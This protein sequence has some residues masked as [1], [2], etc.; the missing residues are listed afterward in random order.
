MPAI[1]LAAG[2]ATHGG[3]YDASA[4]RAQR[5]TLALRDVAYIIR[6]QLRLNLGVSDDI[7]KFR[8]K[9]GAASGKDAASRCHT[10][11]AANSRRSLP[12]QTARSS[13][14]TGP[15][16]GRMLLD[17]EY[18]SDGG[19]SGIPIFFNARLEN[20]VLKVPPRFGTGG[21]ACSSSN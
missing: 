9:F 8:D 2:W 17:L 5:H 7:A 18:A 13:R 4:D 6:A 15:T 12:N 21:G 11:A 1:T 20:G 19:G 14:S 3:G 16:F 10:S